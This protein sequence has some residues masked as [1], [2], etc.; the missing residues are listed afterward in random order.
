[1]AFTPHLFD[2]LKQPLLP[3]TNNDL[4][5]FI[6]RI[7]KSRRHVTG[8]KNTQEFMLRE[9]S[10]VAMLFGLPEATDWTDAFSRVNPDEFHHTLDLLRQTDKRKKCWHARRDLEAFLAALEQ[11]WLPHEGVLQ[12]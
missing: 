4:E 6:G 1:M 9:G 8:R 12:R 7:K 5:L 10:F 11:P 3:R 2:Y